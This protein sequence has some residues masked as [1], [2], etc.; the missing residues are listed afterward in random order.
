MALND[1][2]KVAK[3]IIKIWSKRIVI[4]FSQKPVEIRFKKRATPE[5]INSAVQKFK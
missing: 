5:Q 3:E 2:R 1:L 4:E